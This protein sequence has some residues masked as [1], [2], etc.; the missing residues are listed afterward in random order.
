[1]KGKRYRDG[2]RGSSIKYVASCHF[3]EF[4]LPHRSHCFMESG[5]LCFHFADAELGSAGWTGN[6]GISE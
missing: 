3:L 4:M 1:M 2:E 5:G 6:P